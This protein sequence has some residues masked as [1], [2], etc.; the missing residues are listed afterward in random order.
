MLCVLQRRPLDS[1]VYIYECLCICA[2]LCQYIYAL[3]CVVCVRVCVCKHDYAFVRSPDPPAESNHKE[4]SMPNNNN[5]L[6]KLV[7]DQKLI[8][9]TP[10]VRLICSLSLLLSRSLSRAQSLSRALR[11]SVA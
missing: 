10:S 1:G 9:G 8:I 4:G 2:H 3:M 7:S 11:V 6:A 5:T